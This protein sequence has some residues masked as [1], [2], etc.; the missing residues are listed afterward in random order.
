MLELSWV[1]TRREIFTKQKLGEM[2][3]KLNKFMWNMC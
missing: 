2:F 3:S 1:G